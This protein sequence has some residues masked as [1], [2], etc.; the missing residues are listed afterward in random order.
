MR[1]KRENKLKVKTEALYAF[2][3]EIV[4]SRGCVPAGV[5]EA[6]RGA[7]A[8]PVIAAAVCLDYDSPLIDGVNDSKK[9]SESARD[10]LYDQIVSSARGWAVGSASWQEIDKYNILEATYLAMK[11]ALDGLAC[12]WDYTLIDGNRLVPYIPDSK[13]KT[14]IAGDANSA[15]IAAASI[16]AKVT[17]DRLMVA[18][19]EHYPQYDFITNKGYGTEQHRKVI[20]TCG[21]CEMHRRS[22]C[23]DLVLQTRLEL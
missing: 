22:F 17:R 2:D 16:I 10:R 6:G 19:N 5:D 8:G 18:A 3:R 15:A 4:L 1:S 7:F 20:E 21:L 23:E 11:R 13:Q 14:I 9:L 12:S